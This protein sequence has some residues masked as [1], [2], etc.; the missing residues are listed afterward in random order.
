[1]ADRYLIK[2]HDPVEGQVFSE[3]QL[4]RIARN[5]RLLEEKLKARAAALKN[6]KRLK[7]IA[8][9][10]VQV[11]EKKYR[12][13]EKAL[14]TLRRKAKDEGVYYV[15]A[16]PK[17]IFAIRLA[18]I[19]KLPPKPRKILQLLRLRQ[20]NNGVFIKV[21]Q[22]TIMML[23]CVQPY[24]TYGYPTLHTVRKLLYKRGYGRV[25]WQRTPLVS[26]QIIHTCLGKF[27]ISCMEDLV[28]EIY[29]VG[30]NFKE[31][32]NFLHTFKLRPPKGGWINKRNG[33]NEP[34]G[35]DWGNREELINDL[36]KKMI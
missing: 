1:M 16:Q 4:K 10:N 13:E 22:P 32:N 5:E 34:R 7:M 8:T 21:N 25:N 17:L 31:A 26:N 23:R 35:G 3:L 24:V 18:G 27:G 15:E 14:V 19:N 30:P 36:V 11:Y 12:R 33:F 28:H 2:T 29:T 9:R 6:N 20:I